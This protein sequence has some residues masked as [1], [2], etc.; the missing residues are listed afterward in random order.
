M[1]SSSGMSR[2]AN[3]VALVTGAS[4]GIGAG[5]CASLVEHGM[6]V[7]GCAR[8]KDAIQKISDDLR[9]KGLTGK[10]IPYKCDV[11]DETEVNNLFAYIEANHGGVDVCVN[12]AGFSTHQ[13]LLEINATEMRAMLDVN[14]VGL[15]L[16]AQ[17]SVNSMLTRGVHDGHIININSMAGHRISGFLNFYTA[18]KFA[19]TALNEGLRKEVVAKSRIRVTAISPGAVDTHFAHR[20]VGEEMAKQMYK[21]IDTLSVQDIVDALIFALSAPENSQVHD[22]QIRPTGQKE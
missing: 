7:V 1:A 3:R 22:I 9:D 17:K 8:N 14:V 5:I 11:S 12:N 10:L 15:V 6:T 16:C 13:T 19:V 4:V 21:T 18:T 2:W 20:I